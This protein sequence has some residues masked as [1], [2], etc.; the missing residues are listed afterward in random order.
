MSEFEWI[1]LITFFYFRY[2][3]RCSQLKPKVGLIYISYVMRAFC[4]EWGN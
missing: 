1:V 3:Q 4:R 2:H